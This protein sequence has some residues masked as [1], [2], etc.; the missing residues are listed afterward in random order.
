MHFYLVD[1]R[2][3]PEEFWKKA[4]TAFA[5]MA[6]DRIKKTS[7]IVRAKAASLTE[8]V[9]DPVEKLNRLN[10]YCRRSLVNIDH[11]PTPPGM[12]RKKLLAKPLTPEMVIQNGAGG[13]RSITFLFM[14]LARSLGFD[15]RIALA[16]NW[17]NGAFQKGLMLS[18]YLNEPLVAVKVGEHWKF[19]DP[20]RCQ[21][22]TGTLSSVNEGNQA[23][24]ATPKTV[25][26][27]ILPGTPAAKS[28]RKRTAH[29]QIDED[30]T[31]TGTISIEYTGQALNAALYECY[32]AP[33]KKITL[34]VSRWEKSHI[35][36][37]EVSHVKVSGADDLAQ[38]LRL[39][40]EITV[41][42]YAER[43]GSR[44]FIQPAYFQKGM[45]NEF[46][47]EKRVTDMFFRANIEDIDDVTIDIPA[48]YQIEEGSAPVSK[49][50]EEWGNWGYYHVSLG[51]KKNSG[52]IVYTRDFL[53]KPAF[54]AAAKYKLV[55]TI[56]DHA[57]AQDAHMLSL[58]GTG[59]AA[60]RPA[61]PKPPAPKPADDQ[62]DTD[63]TTTTNTPEAPEE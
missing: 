39:T 38:P 9:T 59:P 56:F 17:L 51:Y 21:V 50:Q 23:L 41:P 11:F 61:K 7:Q 29:F 46:P 13:D 33:A 19:Y 12:D 24:I 15:A 57:F 3:K 62:D 35:P 14:A 20:R 60:S 34:G 27:A 49:G 47:D 45:K 8:G 53:F 63:D 28:Q 1:P 16:A 55:K 32:K 42:E 36:A 10:D 54:V 18:G 37:C 31:L 5:T 6:E 44:L 43:A 25:E 30:G 40:Y 26:W 58:K 52:A 2:L 4:G 48:G 22:T